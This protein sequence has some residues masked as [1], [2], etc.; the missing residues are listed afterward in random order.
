MP[1]FVGQVENQN[2]S[3][4]Y[5]LPLTRG[6]FTKVDREDF[7]RFSGKKCHFDGLYAGT[8]MFERMDKPFKKWRLHRLIMAYMLGTEA[9]KGYQVDHINGDK[10]DNRRG[11][12]RICTVSENRMNKPAP[13]NNKSGFKGVYLI[14]NSQ[15]RNKRWIAYISFNKKRV[16]LGYF[17]T[18][19][20]AVKAYNQGA[21]EYHGEF[22]SLNQI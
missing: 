13:K 14:K 21:K 12:L 15:K 10:L 7:D 20:E 2:M 11:N 1:I 22:A 17:F 9:I 6:E 8:Y 16:V 4:I 18:K 19:D 5:R 3:K